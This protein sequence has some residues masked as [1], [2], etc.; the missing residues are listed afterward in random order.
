MMRLLPHKGIALAIIVLVALLL[1]SFVGNAAPPKVETT[2]EEEKDLPPAYDP[3]PFTNRLHHAMEDR[4]G[5]KANEKERLWKDMQAM[6]DGQLKLIYNY[7]SSEFNESMTER[8]SDEWGHVFMSSK[9][10][11]L[12]RLYALKLI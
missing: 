11:L 5:W 6:T 1:F 12:D 7:Y 4:A 10:K 9:E 8:I 2:T 3:V